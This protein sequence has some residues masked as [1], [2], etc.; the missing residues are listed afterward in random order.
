M[1][2]FFITFRSIDFKTI[3]FKTIGFKAIDFTVA[4]F[5]L[6]ALLIAAAI[7]LSGCLGGTIAQQIARS[8]ATSVADKAVAR[9]M[10]VE[11]GPSNRKPTYT[12]SN[13]ID[14]NNVDGNSIVSASNSVIQ[15][16]ASPLISTQKNIQASPS[17]IKTLQ[18]SYKTE[19]YKQPVINQA[20]V[21][22]AVSNQDP[23]KLAFANAAFEPVKPIAEP[24]PAQLA[25]IETPIAVA[26]SS[27]LVR[28]ELFNLLIG[29]EK[30]AIYAKAQ[31][32]GATT[33]PKQREW[34]LWRV[35]TGIVA[36]TAVQYQ[37]Q[38]LITFLIPP[39]FG[40]LPSGSIAL[41]E[42]ASP[43]ELNIARYKA[44]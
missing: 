30:A 33:L 23:Y 11:E 6:T 15:L 3:V 13:H 1:I 38:Q 37:H 21:N 40:V 32:M 10:D 4:G 34:K 2:K 18:Y 43:G 22:Q 8:I 25:E 31:R 12:A 14:S 26:L 24:L 27:Q 7:S 20:S 35:A 42:L 17:P 5:K 28:V 44:N 36:T 16:G 41:V 19:A 29:E 9:S 39:E